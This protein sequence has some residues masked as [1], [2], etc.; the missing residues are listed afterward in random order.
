MT[1]WTLDH[2]HAEVG[3]SAKHMMVATVKGRFTD[4]QADIKID[5][6]QPQASTVAARVATASLTTG[7]EERDTHLKSPDFLNV[8]EF[9]ELVFQSTSVRRIGED[10]LE[11]AGD[12]TIRDVTRPVVLKGEFTGPIASPWGDRRAGFSLTGEFDREDFGL[13]W[14]VALEAGGV[15]VSR[16]IKLHVDVEVAAALEA[17]A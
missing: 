8:E 12:L 13:T 4:V 17:A 11:L 3:F 14:N 6:E 16:K 7:N 2:T 5:E 9:P 1:T 15:L 10:E